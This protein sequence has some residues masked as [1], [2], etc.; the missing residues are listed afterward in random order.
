MAG[1]SVWRPF[2]RRFHSKIVPE[3]MNMT[4]EEPRVSGRRLR[5]VSGATRELRD[6]ILEGHMAKGLTYTVIGLTC[7]R[8]VRGCWKSPTSTSACI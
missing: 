5:S 1:T 4:S 8:D 6:G 2:L 7:R 3:G